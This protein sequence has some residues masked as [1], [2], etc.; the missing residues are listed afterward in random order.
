[1]QLF[2]TKY[3]KQWSTITLSDSDLLS[4]LRKVLRAKI[5]DIIR[6]QD[7]THETKK[8]RY[9]LSI[10]AWNDTDIQGKI[11][12]EQFHE[13]TPKQTTMIVAMP[14][15]WEKA[16]TIVQKLSEIGID[17]IIFWPSERSIIKERNS[18]KEERIVKIIK[19]AVEQSRWW[20]LPELHFATDIKEY[21]EHTEVIVFDR[22]IENSS[23]NAQGLRSTVWI[24]GPE[25]GLTEKDYQQFTSRPYQI[26]DLGET[27]LRMETAAIVG[28]RLLKN[29]E[30]LITT[31]PR[32]REN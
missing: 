8:V 19:E 3:K 15:K 12:S 25:G 2:V 13:S 29:N 9:E 11:L 18:K 31:C 27:V 6:V 7:P 22:K 4:Q 26:V 30:K 1:M 32:M 14:N 5:G 23:S 16:E 24:V 20:K 17:K 10:Q 28:G 21:L